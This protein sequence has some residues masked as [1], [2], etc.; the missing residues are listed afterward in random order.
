[1]SPERDP[2]RRVARYMIGMY[3]RVM[4]IKDLV[5]VRLYT[6]YTYLQPLVHMETQPLSQVIAGVP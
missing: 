3:Q 6:N 5:S 1:M 2:I 4:E